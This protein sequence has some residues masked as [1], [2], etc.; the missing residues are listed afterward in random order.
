[1]ATMP[2]G[3]TAQSVHVT[4][5]LITALQVQRLAWT[6]AIAQRAGAA[7]STHSHRTRRHFS[8]HLPRR[9]LGKYTAE[10][11]ENYCPGR[12]R[13]YP[14]IHKAGRRRAV[15]LFLPLKMPPAR[16]YNSWGWLSPARNTCKGGELST[17][18]MVDG[19]KIH[20]VWIFTTAMWQQHE[21]RR[22]APASFCR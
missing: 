13:E 7:A 3:T 5:D 11:G 16:P 14:L 10:T 20:V 1:M 15:P 8:Y 22:F 21:E 9:R 6:T 4:C 17:G 18:R 19:W 12:W 2:S